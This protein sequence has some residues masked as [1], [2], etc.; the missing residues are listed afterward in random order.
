M[1]DVQKKKGVAMQLIDNFFLAFVAL[2]SGLIFGFFLQ[3]GGVTK[4]DT[5]VGQLLL[6]DF[7]VMKIILSAILVGG[8]LIS[9]FHSFG[10]ISVMHL[11]K[12]PILLSVIG[13]GIFGIGMS[14][15]GYCPGTALAAL[16]EGDKDLFVGFL[17]MLLG[18]VIF[19]ELST[20][21]MPIMQKPDAYY[22]QTLSSFF[23]VSP[24]VVFAV[25]LGG[26]IVLGKLTLRN[27]TASA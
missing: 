22:E 7:T 21:I 3:K 19:N 9:L 4:F 2:L 11:S 13:G 6:K 17:G 20:W 23:S 26:L 25:L 12:T 24:W 16:A 14:L 18:A 27:K 8:S 10:F 15:L 5:I 1:D